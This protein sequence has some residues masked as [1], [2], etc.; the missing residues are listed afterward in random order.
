LRAFLKRS[1]SDRIR[2]SLFSALPLRERHAL[3]DLAAR[4]GATPEL[5]T[6]RSSGTPLAIQSRGAPLHPPLRD[7]A[8]AVAWQETALDFLGANRALVRLDDPDEELVLLRS[9]PDP[10]GGRC[11]RFRQVWRGVPVWPAELLV[12]LDAGG[13]VKGMRGCH[14]ATP[15][16]LAIAP[17]LEAAAAQA[18][19][20]N[21]VPG[22][23]AAD[24]GPAQLI[25]FAPGDRPPRL[26]WRVT[27]AVSLSQ[28]WQVI[29][30]A[31][32]GA[33][34]SAHNEVATDAAVGSG[35]DLLGVRR[36]LNLFEEGGT[37]FLVDTSKLMFDPSSDPPS[38][39]TTRGAI[40][41]LDARNRP[42][43]SDP[44]TVPQLFQVTSSSATS[45]FLAD[46]VSAAFNLSETYDYYLER[47]NRNSIDGDG[48]QI[49]AS[50][51]LAQ[52]F[53]NAFWDG[54][55]IFLGDGEP[56]A[57]ALDVVAHE[58]THGVTERS[59]N[60]VYLDQSGALNEAFSDIFGEAVE[61]R[62]R[63]ATDWIVGTDLGITLRNL[64]DPSSLRCCFGRNFPERFS[65][66]IFTEEDN[67]GVHI[68]SSILG[69]AFFLLAEGLDGAI[70]IGSAERIFFRALTVKLLAG[71][72]F[73][74]A[75]LAC[76]DSAE[77]IFGAASVEA[78]RTAEAFDAVEI[79]DG[80][81]TPAPDPVP[82]IAA[83][84]AAI[85]L[86]QDPVTER[87]F[88]GRRETAFGDPPD[89]GVLNDTPVAMTRPSVSGDG[90]LAAFIDANDDACFIETDGEGGEGCL[91]MAGEVYSVA[92]SP[93]GDV[94]GLVLL[95]ALGNPLN[96]ITVVDLGPGGATRSFDLRA[97]VQDW[98]TVDTVL[99]AD[100]MDF[101]RDGRLLIYDAINS[102]DFD[103]G[104]EL[105]VWSI[106]ALD[107]E[108]GAVI[109]LAP[110]TPG[111]DIGF[112]SLSQTSDGFLAFDVLDRATGVSTIVAANLQSG[113]LEAVA[114]ASGFGVPSFTGDDRGIV[115]T[116][117]DI[118]AETGA[119]L[120]IQ[121]LAADHI[122]PQGVPSLFLPDAAFGVVYRRGDF[123]STVASLAVT[124]ITAPKRVVLSER[125]PSQTRTVSVE[126]QNRSPEVETIE[127]LGELRE[128]VSLT[129]VS[130][131]DCPAPIPALLV[132]RKSFPIVLKPKAKLRVAFAVTFD[133]A[134]DPGAASPRD[135]GHEDF[136][137]LASVDR[138]ALDGQPDTVPF[139][140][141]CPRSVDPPFEVV[142]GIE[143]VRDR[144]CGAKKP[145][146][147]FGS[148]VLT[149][150][151]E[152]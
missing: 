37:F 75:R 151:V 90:S 78:A 13:A 25:V 12:E 144:G 17:R 95:D 146:R 137:F 24:A 61:A 4:S 98:E 79:F 63:G 74:D 132:P 143:G 62:T 57:A 139:D 72:R 129:V 23:A 138:T 54:R 120:F 83:P 103:D 80:M 43:T 113:E 147:T 125:K 119:S 97:P 58:L 44:Q 11:L 134:N 49:L 92:L 108:S 141:T 30:D 38:P 46:G 136:R 85:F 26:A 65:E 126:I 117:D 96:R 100:A 64:R 111:V 2:Q 71:S 135:P 145:D 10:L 48:E 5:R 109:S 99:F 8:G 127:D 41:V 106:Y 105:N 15:R 89:G 67:G 20:R 121:A 150:V 115:F 51:R 140:D 133:C 68:N 42:P 118:D 101:T 36:P 116:S 81:G 27:L 130:L 14:V 142:P 31:L 94:L 16:G 110:P 21:A 128:L 55:Q 86:F 77:E 114:T 88:L 52:N 19:A 6:R 112:P 22:G 18:R 82:P 149:D 59:A 84:D 28:R 76:V 104:S 40:I 50:V 1:G 32:D 70:G 93:S 56:F 69:H 53:D 124:R 102:I 152:K 33:T 35:V 3:A 39:S 66:F 7:P 60:L 34:L 45:G 148:D 131:G 29:V 9:D 47:H 91:G 87:L 73:I 122:T 123:Q 107:L